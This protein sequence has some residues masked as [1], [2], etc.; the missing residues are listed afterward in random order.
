MAWSFVGR[1]FRYQLALTVSV[2][3]QSYT[4]RSL[5]QVASVEEATMQVKCKAFAA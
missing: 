5:A 4:G 3:P 2:M 1:H